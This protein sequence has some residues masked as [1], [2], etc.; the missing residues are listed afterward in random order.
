MFKLEQLRAAAAAGAAD[1]PHPLAAWKALTWCAAHASDAEARA[2]I[3]RWCATA[4]TAA[5]PPLGE[6]TAPS[7]M[8]DWALRSVLKA[9]PAQ[10]AG[11]LAQAAAALDAAVT[12]FEG[13][14][15]PGAE[16]AGA[17]GGASGGA[18][19]AVRQ[20]AYCAALHA[21]QLARAPLMAQLLRRSDAGGVV[22]RTFAAAARVCVRN[23]VGLR[24]RRLE[25]AA[26]RLRAA[27]SRHGGLDSLAGMLWQDA[28][29]QMA[30]PRLMYDMQR[31]HVEPSAAAWGYFL[32]AH[33][34]RAALA[35]TAIEALLLSR[36]RAAAAS[37][38]SAS[39]A[40][41][42]EWLATVALAYAQRQDARAA[43]PLLA[44]AEAALAAAAAAPDAQEGAQGGAA[45]AAAAAAEGEECSARAKAAIAHVKTALRAAGA[46]PDAA[47]LPWLRALLEGPVAEPLATTTIDSM[48]RSAAGSAPLSQCCTADGTVWWRVAVAHTRRRDAAP[49]A[50]H[51]RLP[52]SARRDGAAPLAAQHTY[53][54][55]GGSA[56]ASSPPPPSPDIGRVLQQCARHRLLGDA[57]AAAIAA[58]ERATAAAAAAADGDGGGGGAA[59][60][61]AL[62]VAQ[63]NVLHVMAACA[64]VGLWPPLLRLLEL[65]ET[66]APTAAGWDLQEPL[67]Q[68]LEPLRLALRACAVA[69]RGAEAQA[70]HRR[71]L[72]VPGFVW[73]RWTARNGERDGESGG[74]CAAGASAAA[75]AAACLPPSSVPGI[76]PGRIVPSSPGWHMKPRA[77]ALTDASAC[78]SHDRGKDDV[79]VAAALFDDPDAAVA[80]LEASWQRAAAAAA[81]GAAPLGGDSDRA[82]ATSDANDDDADSADGGAAS[83]ADEADAEEPGDGADEGRVRCS[84]GA[85]RA[86]RA[87]SDVFTVLV[88]SARHTQ[89]W[90][91]L[92]DAQEAAARHGVAVPRKALTTMACALADGS[93]RRPEAAELLLRRAATAGAAAPP[94]TYAALAAAH[95]RA[96]RWESARSRSASSSRCE[97]ASDAQHAAA[98]VRAAAAS[99]RRRR[100]RGGSGGDAAAF[101]SLAAVELLGHMED[102]G[103]V[104][105][106]AVYAAVLGAM[107]DCFEVKAA[108]AMLDELEA[109]EVETDVAV[110]AEVLRACARCRTGRAATAS[111]ARMQQQGLQPDARCYAWAMLACARSKMRAEVA[112]LHGELRSAGLALKGRAAATVVEALL[113]AALRRDACAAAADLALPLPAY[114]Q[115]R[116]IDAHIAL[117][118][119]DDALRLAQGLRATRARGRDGG[120]GGGDG[121]ARVAPVAAAL[122]AY[123]AA[124]DWPSVAATLADLR[125][126][127]A[128]PAPR[129]AVVGRARARP[130]IDALG[131]GAEVYHAALQAAEACGCSEDFEQWLDE[132]WALRAGAARRTRRAAR[133]AQLRGMRG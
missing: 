119:T 103:V 59:A 108:V 25:R 128:M 4:P 26:A 88:A 80:H 126:C 102:H 68:A 23:V 45:A 72:T 99:R 60:G 93:A 62:G 92:S 123:G 122:R 70:L 30:M 65:A 12:L 90:H 83:D 15:A 97:R 64:S 14:A 131:S 67:R 104:P 109:A 40:R 18:A 9:A 58:M 71:A 130:E 20:R 50:G 33:C 28:P 54:T 42:A 94:S 56:A 101:Q 41:A 38:P 82:A 132:H 34:R 74:S 36:P 129:G 8:A 66:A 121:G 29:S 133:A 31:E 21:C 63:D 91:V 19:A 125:A 37:S 11:S 86:R 44:R 52:R 5:Y 89:R 3:E 7:D 27:A 61:C 112:R 69:R 2:L 22:R 78:A 73:R 57:A 35:A 85:S 75:A 49:C 17:S 53:E 10:R 79:Q 46:A 39:A 124:R 116:L 87:L 48:P 24:T 1:A 43:E 105:D 32:T 96:R 51:H 114:L 55:S 117:G 118:Q 110:Y 6:P 106:G 127:G 115:A 98:L 111:L 100:L 77:S 84:D 76:A 16:R 95:G 113:A 81:A 120:G 107:A 13:A 47:L